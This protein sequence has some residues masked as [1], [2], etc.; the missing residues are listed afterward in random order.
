M[1][2]HLF[3]FG[4]GPPFTPRLAKQFASLIATEQP[5]SIMFL[6][7]DG[8]K[9]YMPIVT[10]PLEQVGRH[11]FTYIP[12]QS[13]PIEKAIRLLK[14]SSGVIICGGDTNTYADFIVDSELGQVIKELYMEGR[15]ITGF[16]AGALICPNK[17][18][19]SAKDND[20]QEYQLRK[21]VG[22]LSN[23]VLAVHLTEWDDEE[24]FSQMVSQFPFYQNFGLHEKTGIRLLNE[25]LI[26]MEGKGVYSV[27]NKRLVKIGGK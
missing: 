22:L 3:L 7:R 9:D 21:G 18:I 10:E 2:N 27:Q 11:H 8:W 20:K 16:S 17:C 19:I 15:P 4:S 13:A 23:T 1:D 24:H 25:E 6:E 26:D 14:E 5:I 12:L